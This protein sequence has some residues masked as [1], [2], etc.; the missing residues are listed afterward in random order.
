M[1]P[2][3][4]ALVLLFSYNY[5]DLVAIARTVKQNKRNTILHKMSS[6]NLSCFTNAKQKFLVCTTLYKAVNLPILNAD[7]YAT[8]SIE[9]TTK[10]TTICK[11]CDQPYF[12][13]YF[14]FEFEC[15]LVELLRKCLTIRVVHRKWIC[16]K[17]VAIGEVALHLSTVWEATSKDYWVY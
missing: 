10:R 5:D 16:K 3:V 4:R 13:E 15:P 7:I 8:V 2:V 6:Y 14:V 1:F 17:D 11:S 12:N 9:N